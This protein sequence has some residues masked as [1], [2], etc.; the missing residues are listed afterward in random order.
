VK[1]QRT[2]ILGVQVS[3]INLP[4][5]L[6][7]IDEW[8]R[9]RDPHYICVTGVHGV[10][11]SQRDQHLLDIHNRAGMVTP[12]GMP[13]VW[14]SRAR[15]FHQ[16]SRVYGPDLM[17]AVLDMSVQ[18]GYRHFLYGGAEGV[19][20]KLKDV[21]QTRFPGTHI[22][23]TYCPPFRSLNDEEK[24]KVI[25]IIRA[26]DPDILWVGLSTPK[27][28]YWMAQ[29]VD[30]LQVPALIGVGAAFDF[31]SGRKRQA[32]L[33]MQRSGLEW[34]FRLVTE[35]NRLWK[36]YLVNNPQFILLFLAQEFGLRKYN[37]N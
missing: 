25:D 5:A 3:A 27:Q 4:I 13:L 29:F 10:M 26:C 22:V 9:A 24:R 31:L 37:K 11:E 32:P 8:I 36:R 23:G 30:V 20:E 21:I 15:G 6:E 7:Q 14:I 18:K 19:A 34:L 1:I 17:T 16:V 33:W 12:D 28:E 35:P 2:N